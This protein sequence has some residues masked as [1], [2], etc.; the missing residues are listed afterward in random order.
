MDGTTLFID[1]RWRSA[2]DG[3]TIP[4]VDPS[5]G[6]TFSALSR[7]RAAEIDD[8]VA[9]AR[10]AYDTVWRRVSPVE[11]G[12]ILA[13]F[14]ELIQR[15]HERIAELECRDVGKPLA[16]AQKDITAA[17]RYCEFYGGAADKLHG[18]TLPYEAGYTVLALREPFG[19][20]GHLIPW[21]Y[22][23][24]MFG[25]S[26]IASLAAGNT[27]VVKPGEDA[28]LSILAMVD[29]AM[30]AGLPEGVLNVVTGFG[31]EAGAALA[32]HRDV[33]HI[34]FTGSPATGTLV[35]QAAAVHN[36]PAT[37]E[38]GGKS[39]QIIFA[40]ADLEA[41][42]PVLYGALVQNAGQTCSAGSR[43]LVQR[44]R[45]DEVVSA[46]S[47]RFEATRVGPA[48][49][50]PDVGPL[51]SAR[52]AERVKAFIERAEQSE[53]P[54]A[55]VAGTATGPESGFYVRPQLFAPV[56]PA[57]ELS[58]QEV[59]GPVL[60]ATPFDDEAHALQLANA[61]DYGLV[62]GVWTADGGR[63]L[64]MSHAL[65]AGQVF[66]NCYGAGGGV[67]LPFGGVKRS[68]YGREKGMEG[69]KSF[70]RIKTVAV[71]HG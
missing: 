7:G 9:A 43:I 48:M 35:Q 51:I 18:E 22:P 14:G 5:T 57:N 70:T 69:L 37:M 66:V 31:N 4:V 56:D 55:A 64:R 17:S 60:V 16:Q 27:V 33:N 32:G 54:V 50:D 46:L 12:R 3:E 65:E 11:R 24:Q 71:H 10:R 1:G 41:A 45:F 52:Q 20:T 23:A 8:A 53:L 40:D 13:R 42:L 2:A 30:E 44:S 26:V 38:L 62:A 28:C 36:V 59:F 19:V 63:Q 34:S 67:E 29:L 39:P 61:T 68:G 21:N 49:E 58:H 15:D 25:R 47:A 6:E